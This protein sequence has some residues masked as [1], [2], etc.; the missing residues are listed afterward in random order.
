MS[1]DM[2]HI[3]VSGGLDDDAYGESAAH[4]YNVFEG[5]PV[6]FANRAAP[7]IW[8][9][10]EGVGAVAD[11][12]PMLDVGCGTGQ[13]ASF[14]LERGARVTGLDRSDHMLRFAR[15]NNA[16]FVESGQ[17]RFIQTDASDFCLDER[18]RVAT[19]TFNC[20][21]HLTDQDALEGYLAS[22][23]RAL[24]PGGYFLFDFNTRRGLM[25]TVERME[26]SDTEEDITVW[27]RHSEGDRVVLYASGCFLDAGIWHRY[28]ETINKIIVEAEAVRATML[29]QGWSSVVFTEDDYATPVSDPEA[30]D[31]A[32][33]VART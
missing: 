18:F 7:R 19:S 10:L 21:N 12:V 5:R 27:L 32:Y 30:E 15:H 11:G 16:R 8:S 9:A 29:D 3:T 22:V 24:E 2:A 31:V 23:L 1:K 26:I 14:F 13:L 6:G 25:N 17:A 4:R 20:L 28:R 33:V